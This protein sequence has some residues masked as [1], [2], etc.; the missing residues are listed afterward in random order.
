MFTFLLKYNK[1][2]FVYVFSGCAHLV[3][4]LLDKLYTVQKIA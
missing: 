1:I 2:E 4:I 3:Q